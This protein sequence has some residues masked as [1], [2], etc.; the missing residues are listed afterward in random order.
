LGL[1]A[2]LAVAP[3]K[4]RRTLKAELELIQAAS[5]SHITVDCRKY[6]RSLSEHIADSNAIHAWLSP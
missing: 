1:Q 5:P 3:G 4:D 6:R 2:T